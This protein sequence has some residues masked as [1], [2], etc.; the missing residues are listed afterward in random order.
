M[1][2]HSAVFYSAILRSSSK[3]FIAAMHYPFKNNTINDVSFKKKNH[4]QSFYDMRKHVTIKIIENE[5]EV[6]PIR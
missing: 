2:N 6:D 4:I 1:I 3:G 5:T